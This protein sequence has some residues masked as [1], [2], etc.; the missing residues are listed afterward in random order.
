MLARCQ[1]LSVQGR[2]I[3]CTSAI[4]LKHGIQ[5]PAK[6][7]SFMLSCTQSLLSFCS[8]IRSD[9]CYFCVHIIPPYTNQHAITVM[10]KLIQFLK[11]VISGTDII[12]NLRIRD[13]FSSKNSRPIR[14]K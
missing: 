10:A 14:G 8:L 13:E 3:A 1:M 4:L 9:S 6:V 11:L 2:G 7:L 12:E 5:L